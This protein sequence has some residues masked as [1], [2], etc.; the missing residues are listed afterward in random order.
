MEQLVVDPNTLLAK[1][2]QLSP[3]ALAAFAASCC[4]RMLPNY[5]R[6]Q[7]EQG[8]GTLS[9]LEEAA[10]AVWAFLRGG[11]LLADQAIALREACEAAAPDTESFDSI[12]VSSALDAA[13]ALAETIALCRDPRPDHAL[14]VAIA[15]RDS[16]DMYIQMTQ[17]LAKEGAEM[18]RAIAAHPLMLREIGKQSADLD[19]LASKE[20]LDADALLRLRE[21][22]SYDMFLLAP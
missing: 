1:L 19:T 22:A 20:S 5:A 21:S 7:R 9:A 15:A 3:R 8:W 16:V 17:D 14:R 6:F 13:G 11:P 18:E 4:Q 12:F 2:A 10:E